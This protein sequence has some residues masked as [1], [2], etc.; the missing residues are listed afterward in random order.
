MITGFA[1]H[2]GYVYGVR[3]HERDSE[4]RRIKCNF[5][6]CLLLRFISWLS[7]LVRDLENDRGKYF[8][9]KGLRLIG[10]FFFIRDEKKMIELFSFRRNFIRCIIYSNLQINLELNVFNFNF[11][12]IQNSL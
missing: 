10:F 8:A 9:T 5:I 7:V 12:S 1:F 6:V 2:V 4:R 3:F 11:C